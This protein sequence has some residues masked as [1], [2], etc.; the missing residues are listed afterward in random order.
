MTPQ[1]TLNYH[2]QH[3]LDGL[4]APEFMGHWT[5]ISSHQYCHLQVRAR[6][7]CAT[8]SGG[9]LFADHNSPQLTN[10][11]T[12]L[13]TERIGTSTHIQVCRQVKQLMT[14]PLVDIGE[15]RHSPMKAGFTEE[16]GAPFVAWLM[17]YPPTWIQAAPTRSR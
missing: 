4:L 8:E 12:P 2:L 6:H 7:M 3:Q 16:L 14:T 13:A 1:Q 11:R 15:I 9:R 10:W 5:T 17:G